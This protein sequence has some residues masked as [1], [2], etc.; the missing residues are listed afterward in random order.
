MAPAGVNSEEPRQPPAAGLS[1]CSRT[2]VSEGRF[3]GASAFPPERG[4][5]GAGP[6]TPAEKLLPHCTVFGSAALVPGPRVWP[7][8]QPSSD[9]PG[10]HPAGDQPRG[11]FRAT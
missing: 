1:P 10:P 4:L 8:G 5:W 9:A 6:C 7:Q 3:I 11:V 2:V